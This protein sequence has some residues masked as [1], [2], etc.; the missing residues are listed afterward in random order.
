MVKKQD[1]WRVAA[2]LVALIVLLGFLFTAMI[3]T[4]LKVRALAP[5]PPKIHGQSI[6]ESTVQHIYAHPATSARAMCTIDA[7][8]GRVIYEHSASTRLS[9]AST[10]KIITAIT[11]IEEFAKLGRSLDEKFIINEKAIGI[12]GTSIYLQK[13]E[14]LTAREL[15]LGLMLR[16]GNDA[17]NALAFSV[18]PTIAD[19][20]VLMNQVAERA[21]AIDSNF[22]NPHGLD[23]EGHYTTARDLARIT[24]YAMK[25][26]AFA[27]IVKTQSA[28]IDGVEIPRVL[29]NKNRLLKSLDGCIG[30]KTGFTKKAG[31]CYVAARETN[32]QTIICVVL[33]CG[34][35]FE[36]AADLMIAAAENYPMRKLI[37][38]DEFIKFS[39]GCDDGLCAIAVEDFHY[40]ISSDELDKNVKITLDGEE[41]TVTLNNKQIYKAECNVI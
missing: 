20:S 41:V 37:V 14:Q 27:E 11:I 10:T 30:V 15:L 17:A 24:A 12:E 13:G 31:R 18:K 35:M 3:S 2:L 5:M 32:G 1:I 23:E 40:P 25:N 38:A 9:L 7:E 28:R 33:N 34:P 29:H 39:Q 6:A 21:G 26:P 22:K 4:K 19:F 8:T 16:S 36:E